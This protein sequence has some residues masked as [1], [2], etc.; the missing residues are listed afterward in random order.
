MTVGQQ[1]DEALRAAG[2]TK[3][4]ARDRSVDLLE[5]MGIE[6]AA[7]RL[8]DYP[9]QFSGG[10][11]QRIVIAIAIATEPA[12]LLADEPT[13]ALDVTTQSAMLKLFREISVER[14]MS[15]LLISHNYAVVSQMCSRTVVLYAGHALESGSTRALLE[16]S[17]HPYTRGLIAS[18]PSLDRRV[19]RLPAIRGNP[20]GPG[21]E[22]AG[23]PFRARCRHAIGACEEADMVLVPVSGDHSTAC[24]RAAELFAAKCDDTVINQV[25]GRAHDSQDARNENLPGR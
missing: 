15:M 14:G 6:G 7:A 13:S 1:V 19:A 11:R 5:R 22:L 12:L 3:R 17:Q 9:H 10:Q 21:E 4:S 18:V 8:A 20:P 25:A 24:I 23:C 2:S 16:A